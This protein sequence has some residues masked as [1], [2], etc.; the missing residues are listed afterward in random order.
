MHLRFSIR[1]LAFG[2]VF[3]AFLSGCGSPPPPAAKDDAARGAAEAHGDH[4]DHDKPDAHA[5]HGGHGDDHGKPDAHDD[6]DDHGGGEADTVHLTDA[7]IAAARI[8][9][10]PVRSDLAGAVEASAV[11]AADPTRSAIAAA[12][13]G[14]RIAA[15][16]R[17]LGEPV[18]RGDVLVVLESREAA[19]LTAEVQAARS[20]MQQAATTL[21][22]EERLF[23]ERVSA[24]QDVIAA[25][26]NAEA[27]RIRLRLAQD[28]LGAAGGS[29]D[30]ASNRLT[31]RAPSDGFV[32]DRHAELGAVVAADS[33]LFRVADLSVVSLD[34]SLAPDAAHAVRPGA[35]VAVSGAGRTGEARIAFVAPI[36]DP[37]TRQ[38]RALATLPNADGAWRI[39][40]TVSVRIAR[41]DAAAG[42]A[43]P[44]AAIQT[45]EDKPSVFV[46]TD[47]GFAVKHLVLGAANGD[48]VLVESGLEG[49]ERIAVANSYVIK[50]EL[51][52]GEGGEHEH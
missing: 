14:G 33:E 31:V 49:G 5:E 12:A 38:V 29:G 19:D 44:R 24:E 37:A 45:V 17:N 23:K 16:H 36:I 41:A 39:G 51:G 9:V 30:G 32:I 28:R 35:A 11:V 7:Q 8:A 2:L 13:V 4:G 47:K 20:Q 50:A 6:H 27:A 52:K 26:A 25:R 15:V 21:E 48:H 10:E 43:V 46:R 22:R 3:S 18:K 40:E 34:L 42:I 1:W